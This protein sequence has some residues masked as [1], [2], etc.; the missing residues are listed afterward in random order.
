M[1]GMILRYK[2]CRVSGKRFCFACVVRHLGLEGALAARR[3]FERQRFMR[4]PITGYA[5][6]Q[7]IATIPELEIILDS[8]LKQAVEESDEGK[9]AEITAVARKFHRLIER[10]KEHERKCPDGQAKDH[11]SPA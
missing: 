7:L 3:I 10:L 6:D 5:L 4:K 11:S 1:R 8:L 2:P 9:N